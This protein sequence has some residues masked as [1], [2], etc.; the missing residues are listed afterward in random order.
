VISVTVPF[1]PLIITPPYGSME[2]YLVYCVY[3]SFFCL[4][5]CTVTDFS[6]AEKARSMKFCT[7]VGLLC[8]QVFSPFGEDWLAGSHG[9]ALLLG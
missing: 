6:A 1:L 2:G 8:G 3:V 4:F 7:H 5:V 9:V